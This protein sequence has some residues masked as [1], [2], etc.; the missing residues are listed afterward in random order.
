[1]RPVNALVAIALLFVGIG[2]VRPHS[3]RLADEAWDAVLENS[4]DLPMVPD[5]RIELTESGEYVVFVDGPSGHPL[6]EQAENVYPD[7]YDLRG[8]RPIP[9][10]TDGIDTYT[11]ERT[12]RRGDAL[13]KARVQTPGT[14]KLHLGNTA[15]K[16]LTA[17]GFSLAVC[18]AKLVNE[19]S[20]KSRG[21]RYAGF[22][23]VG[24]LGLIAFAM[25]TNKR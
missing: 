6:W 15:W 23:L 3:A 12:G 5:E 16:E 2:V 4:Q 10:T 24:V 1:M 8:N 20:L 9:A 7:L 19:Q 25:F 21:L 11:Y 17:A 13:I 22:G 18:R 14:F